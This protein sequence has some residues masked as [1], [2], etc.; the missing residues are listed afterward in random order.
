LKQ[1]SSNLKTDQTHGEDKMHFS[2]LLHF[3]F[4]MQQPVQNPLFMARWL[5]QHTKS[6]FHGTVA[7]S[8][9]KIHFSWHGGCLSTQ[10]PRTAAG[11]Y[12]Y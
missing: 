8:A 3:L 2:D 11:H 5:P 9:H 12:M 6:T 4:E 7:A 10:N 1:I